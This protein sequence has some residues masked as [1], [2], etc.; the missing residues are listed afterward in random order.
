MENLNPQHKPLK[1]LPP[2]EANAAPSTPVGAR[3]GD[4]AQSGTEEPVAPWAIRMILPAI[5]TVI[6]ILVVRW[7]IKQDG[8]E[9]LWFLTKAVL[10]LSFVIFIHELGH[11]VVA[12]WCDVHVQTFSIGFGPAVP[13]C[14]FRRGE[15]L[16]KIALF[17]LGGYVKM[18]GEGTEEDDNPDDPRSFKKKTVGQRMT[19][20]SAGVLMNALLAAAAFSVAYLHGV[21]RLPAEVA[22]VDPGY[23]AWQKGL[24]S[25]ALIERIGNKQNPYFDDLQPRVMHS[26]EGQK[27]PLVY[28]LRSAP[29]DPIAVEI[30]PRRKKGD[31]QP[32]IGISPPDELKLFT[33][34]E[35]A[36][37]LGKGL[38]PVQTDSVA[39]QASPSFDFGD[40]IVASTDPADPTKVTE[41][42]LSN[43]FDPDHKRD[44]FAFYE[45]LAR[46]A[47]QPM[48]IRVQRQQGKAE[49]VSVDIHVPPAY[50]YTFGMQ[51]RMG[52]ITA[53]R[54]GS[55]AAGR[56]EV[57]D[58]QHPYGDVIKQVEVTE[59]D[60]S[61]TRFVTG[62]KTTAA[63]LNGVQEKVLDPVR[64][65]YE[66]AK[67]AQRQKGPKK[68]QL[69]V[70]RIIVDSG[71]E[72][73]WEEPPLGKSEERRLELDWDDAWKFSREVATTLSS[74][75]S[76]PELGLAYQVECEIESVQAGSPAEE[77]GLKAGDTIEAIQ[78]QEWD[79]D[80][81]KAVWASDWID[82]KREQWARVFEAVQGTE[83]K[84]I[85]LRV[86]RDK[87]VKEFTLTPQADVSWPM[88]ERGLLLMP[89][90]RLQVADSVGKAIS[91][92]VERTYESITMTLSHMRA[93]YTGRVAP[94]KGLSG[95]LTIANL[96]YRVAGED[97]FEFLYFLGAISIS[98]AVINFLPIPLLDGGHMAF[99]L[100][101]KIRGRPAPENVQVALMYLGLLT[102]LAIMFFALYVDWQNLSIF[103]SL[104]GK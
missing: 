48:V 4:H 88:I 67:W 14:S 82:L 84:T 85:R 72:W 102:I 23:P 74:P 78:L 64:L 8:L 60:G 20:I 68:V 2:K 40:V 75:L 3:S 5:F 41:I 18:V 98:L 59:P 21:K 1:A 37:R 65:P 49:P 11:F 53:V 66:L 90:Y 63:P 70:D 51:M 15:T 45:R 81:Q 83:F 33:K 25:G 69:V 100:Y 71:S 47:G 24:R 39:T 101:E 87:E 6:L 29:E 73:K 17:P 86:K 13:G 57:R 27:L 103:K 93:M 44:Y 28:A 92:G 99:L 56:V 35:R 43:P 31:D 79:E 95:P 94:T 91:L 96:A 62:K 77:A 34:K 9:G 12:K 58:P 19:I 54:D 7:A 42:P 76:I 22:L 38:P 50:H 10:G 16:Y 55:P 32:R 80:K 52:K 36:R 97:F 61:R 26:A 89:E 104:F 46:L 30:E